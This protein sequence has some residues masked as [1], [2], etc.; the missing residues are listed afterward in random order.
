MERQSTRIRRHC[1]RVPQCR[2]GAPRA[3]PHAKMYEFPA[4]FD[5][6]SLVG[7]EVELVS[8]GGSAVIVAFDKDT[9]ISIFGS[10]THSQEGAHA[11]LAQVP[12]QESRLMRLVG[13]KITVAAVE[14]DSTLALRFSNGDTLRC[15]AD[16][17]HYECFT[18]ETPTKF[19][20]V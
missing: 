10:Y 12:P 20:V 15:L 18:I 9:R 11:E 4:D 6:S 19:V 17:K 3:E 8:F 7:R 14:S 13:A 5:P 16:S 1:R 2:S